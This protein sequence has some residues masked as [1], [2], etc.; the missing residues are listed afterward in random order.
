MATVTDE[1]HC[2]SPLFLGLYIDV[3][4]YL[5]KI[6]YIFASSYPELK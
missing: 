5:K 1:I 4:S 3:Q 6:R 2:I